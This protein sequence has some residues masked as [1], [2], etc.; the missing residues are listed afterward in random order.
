MISHEPAVLD[1]AADLEAGIGVLVRRLRQLQGAGDLTL[2]ESAALARLDRSGSATSAELARHEHVT[3][4]SMGAILATLESR[5]F[6]ERRRDPGD[7]RRV[8]VSATENGSRA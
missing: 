3:P 2:S 4:Q 1:I 8:L 7:A 6:V 5:G